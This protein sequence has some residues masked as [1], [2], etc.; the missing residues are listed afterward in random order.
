MERRGNSFVVEPEEASIASAVERM[1][2]PRSSAGASIDVDASLSLGESESEGEGEGEGESNGRWKPALE[3][4]AVDSSRPWDD[5][6]VRV[7]RVVVAACEL[8]APP[9]A[10]W[11]RRL[12]CCIRSLVTAI[13][14]RDLACECDDVSSSPSH[15]TARRCAGHSDGAVDPPRRRESAGRAAADADRAGR[16]P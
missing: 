1:E 7:V 4:L 3:I 14:V 8:H 6:N 9:V 16:E 15:S 12:H 10:P 13:C 2:S 5:N 11:L